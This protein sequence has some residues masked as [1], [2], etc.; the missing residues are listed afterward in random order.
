MAPWKGVVEGEASNPSLSDQFF[1]LNPPRYWFTRQLQQGRFALWNPHMS[2]GVPTIAAPQTALLFPI[3]L[4]LTPLDPFTAAA[5]AAFMKLWLAGVFTLMYMR[6]I[7]TSRPAALFSAIAFCLS[8]FMVVWLGHPH[9]N[10]AMWLPLLLYFVEKEKSGRVGFALTFACM[11]LGGHYPTVVLVTFGVFVYAACRAALHR[12]VG[13]TILG[14][15]FT[16]PQVLPFFE[17]Y[18]LSSLSESS[19]EMK[20]WAIQLDLADLVVYLSPARGDIETSGYV[21]VLTLVL[22]V[23]ALAHRPCRLAIG[24]AVAALACLVIIYVPRSNLTL[25]GRLGPLSAIN[26]TRLA[27]WVGFALA[28]LAG[29]GLDSLKG[30]RCAAIAA[31]VAPVIVA[32]ELLHAGMGFNPTVSRQLYYPTPPAIEFLQ[33]E[34]KGTGGDRVI[35]IEGVLPPNL[36]MVYGLSDSRGQDFMSLRRYEQLITGSTGYF[37]FYSSRTPLPAVLPQL[38]VK[39]V[40]A[41]AQVRLPERYFEQ[42]YDGEISIHRLKRYQ[43]RASALGGQARIVTDEPNRVVIETALPQPATLELLDTHFPGWQARVNGQHVEIQL[44]HGN[45]RAVAVPEGASIVEFRYRPAGFTI[46]CALALAAMVILVTW[47]GAKKRP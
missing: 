13:S 36:P 23:V 47:L 43:P 27:M 26:Y 3:N 34:A 11:V 19:V 5:F 35:G 10:S 8:G 40:L 1:R 29:L 9:V 22:V 15:L 7:G 12:V 32:F 21:G 39:H 28:V 16:A 46:G 30:L 18:R 42:V 41:P 4:A 17:Y 44:A 24:W 14:T 20:R 37:Y 6:A 33:R 45:F 25:L 31:A 38:G 2:C